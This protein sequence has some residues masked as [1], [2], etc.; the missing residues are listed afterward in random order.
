MQETSMSNIR[1]KLRNGDGKMRRHQCGLVERRVLYGVC[2]AMEEGQKLWQV[3]S[4][5]VMG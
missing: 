4:Y 1:K 5:L 2:N 3:L